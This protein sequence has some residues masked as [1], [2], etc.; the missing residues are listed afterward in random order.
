MNNARGFL[1]LATL[2][3]SSPLVLVA[4]QA[5]EQ[6]VVDDPDQADGDFRFQGEYEGMFRSGRL[7]RPTGLQVIALGGGKFDAVL[8]I[9][10][11]PGTG[12]NETTQSAMHG[13][14]NEQGQLSLHGDNVSV[15]LQ[16]GKGTIKDLHQ[17]HSGRLHKVVRYSSTLG[18]S[19]ARNALV[20]FDGDMPEHFDGA[21]ITE[22]GLLMEGVTTTM[23]VG[24]FQLHLEFRIPYMPLA[25]GQSRGNSGV[26]IQRRYEVQILDSF[27]LAGANNECGGIY[28]QLEPRINMC[29]PP[30]SWQTYDLLFRQARWQGD[31]KIENARITV[32]HN[33]VRIHSKQ[34]ITAKTGAGQKETAVPLPIHLQ[35]H[36][37]PVRFRNIWL[38]MDKQRLG[39]RVGW[40]RI[41]G[42]REKN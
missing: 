30:L 40:S 8:Y 12:W 1:L 9:G 6:I 23:P 31:E 32:L 2:L 21:R 15:E 20:L 4:Q 24:D 19:P 29:L 33:G 13:E 10:G 5:S 7:P 34:P 28:R 18:A 37:N 42:D 25:R 22:D 35:N 27:G 38:V 16:H 3:A 41:T 26:Y 36:G 39:Q 11:L 17:G 14:V